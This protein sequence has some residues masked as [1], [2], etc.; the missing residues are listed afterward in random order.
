MFCL[1]AGDG[2]P[3]AFRQI[4]HRRPMSRWL[5]SVAVLLAFALGA[6]ASDS[7]IKKVSTLPTSPASGQQMYNEYCAVCHGKDGK[8]SGPAAPGLTKVPS[9]LTL[10]TAHNNG[11]YPDRKVFYIIQGDSDT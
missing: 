7:T 2:S 10:L 4:V 8:G 1:P 6:S 11:K 9:D 3:T 5:I